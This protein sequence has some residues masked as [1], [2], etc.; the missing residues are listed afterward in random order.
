MVLLTT[1][2][3]LWLFSP[4]LCTPSTTN[5]NRNVSY[6]YG[7]DSSFQTASTC[8]AARSPQRVLRFNDHSVLDGAVRLQR[9]L[10]DLMQVCACFD[11]I[12][13]KLLVGTIKPS[14]LSV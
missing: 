12:V 10:L 1:Q 8:A 4:D 3:P 7:Q 9:L 14:V 11:V 6:M 2:H 5:L 13:L